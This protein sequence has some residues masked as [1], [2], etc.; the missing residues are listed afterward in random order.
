MA[1]LRCDDGTVV[2]ISTE[3]EKELRKVFGKPPHVWMHGDVF[4]SGNPHN[5]GVLMY[6][7]V[8]KQFGKRE[9][10]VVYVGRDTHPYDSIEQYLDNATFLFNIED[11]L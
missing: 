1:E 11:K 8:E 2:P 10:Q 3:T 5:Q 7:H 9:P 6:L 4:E